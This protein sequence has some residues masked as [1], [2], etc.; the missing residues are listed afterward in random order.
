MARLFLGSLLVMTLSLSAFAGCEDGESTATDG[1]KK[2]AAKTMT[3]CRLANV[4]DPIDTARGQ[5]FQVTLR[6]N[7]G[8]SPVYLVSLR[9]IEDAFC[10]L[11]KVTRITGKPAPIK[12]TCPRGTTLDCMPVATNPMCEQT[13]KAWIKKNCRGVHISE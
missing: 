6:C 12:R 8:K 1:A 10:V 5:D 11:Q 7:G 3:G 4:S 13:Y 2:V 9:E